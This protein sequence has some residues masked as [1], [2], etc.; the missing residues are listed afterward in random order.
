MVS[1]RILTC[2]TNVHSRALLHLRVRR[3][4]QDPIDARDERRPDVALDEGQV[5]RRRRLLRV[6]DV[7]LGHGGG[8]MKNVR[9]EKLN[10]CSAC[11]W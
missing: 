6:A 1:I 7:A 4:P 2:D 11:S 5:L 10:D 8:E 3:I 9:E